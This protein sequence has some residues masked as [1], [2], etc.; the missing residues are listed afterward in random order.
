[1]DSVQ[2]NTVRTAGKIACAGAAVGAAVGGG[3]AY[4]AQRIILK[5]PDEFIKTVTGKVAKKKGFNTPFFKGTKEA[6]DLANEKLDE[7]LKKAVEF[8]KSGKYNLKGIAKKA[9]VAA[10]KAAVFCAGIYALDKFV[11]YMLKQ[12]CKEAAQAVN[13]T[14]AEE[15]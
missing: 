15:A 5:N 2:N 14:K 13:E 3:V 11:Q 9:G 1:M 6:A 7:Y 8:A 12:G 10:A 4:M